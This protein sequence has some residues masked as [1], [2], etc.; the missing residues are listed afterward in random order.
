MNSTV[1]ACVI[2]GD[3]QTVTELRDQAATIAS[4]VQLVPDSW[5]A[6]PSG[7]RGVR[8]LADAKGLISA[9]AHSRTSGEPLLI[10]FH[11]DIPSE[12]HL[13]LIA[14]WCHQNGIRLFVG[15]TEFVWEWPHDELDFALR[16]QLDAA[17]DLASAVAA[18]ALTSCLDDVVS[19]LLTQPAVREVRQIAARCLR[20]HISV[21][22][23]PDP[24]RSWEDGRSEQVHAFVAWLAE[25]RAP[26]FVA[27]VLN[28]LGVRSRSG[29][30]WTAASVARLARSPLALR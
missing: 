21:P 5:H 7:L 29:R 1:S 25:Y 28:E 3:E 12:Q 23:E 24:R 26:A 18:A 30:C 17:S 9:L 19:E 22:A 13:R 15:A 6:D 4:T 27:R 10:P 8:T 11:A 20:E 14:Q 16:A 2:Y